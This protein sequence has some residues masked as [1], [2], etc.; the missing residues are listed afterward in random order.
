M[1]IPFKPVAIRAAASMPTT[2][3][4]RAFVN[5]SQPTVLMATTGQIQLATYDGSAFT[6]TM[7]ATVTGAP[8]WVEFVEPNKLYAVDEWGTDMR[9]YHLELQGENGTGPTLSPQPVASAQGS[10]GVVHLEFT[11]DKTRMVGAAYGSGSIDVWDTT[12]DQL[13][14]ITTIKS[15]GEPGPVKPNQET[16]HPH[17][18]V[19]EPSGRYFA[20]N[21]LGT[22]EILVIDSA[23]D[24]WEVV[25]TVPTPAGCG[26][27]HGVFYGASAEAS[28][29]T[30]YLVVCEL[31]NTVISYALTYEDASLAFTE[32]GQASTFAGEAPEGAAA[33]E[34]A[35]ASD[36]TNLY[37]S[38]RLTGGKSDSIA[39]F[40]VTDGVPTLV[41]EKS[42]HGTLP[43]MFS[44][45]TSEDEIFI[46]NQNGPE[47]VVALKRTADGEVADSPAASLPLSEFGGAEG[48]GPAY[49][50][51]IR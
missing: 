13:K 22:D 3:G 24:A 26:P 50:K 36:N 35:L 8:T 29:A 41:D 49:I 16:A 43:R 37:A 34:L 6:N 4:K 38:N 31:S 45:S 14:L 11:Q 17:Q 47:A 48:F 39:R 18:A 44:L 46:G 32:A 21:D 12:G 23:D 15:E 10:S 42:T 1:K 7:N 20:V 9:L 25:N 19:L 40:T 51:Q 2:L 33:G 27:R 28:E 5:D 30:H